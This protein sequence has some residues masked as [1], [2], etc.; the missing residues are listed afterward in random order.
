MRS[1][2]SR[3]GSILCVLFFLIILTCATTVVIPAQAQ[4]GVGTPTPSA[5]KTPIAAPGRVDVAPVARD[6]EIR[7]RLEKILEATGWFQ[8][9]KVEV[10]DGVVF[11]SGQTDTEEYKKWAGDLARN[12]QDVTAVVNQIELTQ[13]SIWDIQPA[14]AG[15]REM[16]T[17]VLR[18]I[19]LIGFGILVLLV[20]WIV[21]RLSANATR[22]ALRKRLPNPLLN[23]VAG[24]ASGV[25]VFLIGLYI[26]F[27][28]AGLA[29]VALTV[30]GG[31]GILGLILG[32]A[33]RDIS[34]NFLSSIF[35]SLQ[36]PF[37]IGDTVN[38]GNSTGIVQAL[39]T[40]ATVLHTFDGN[41]LQI[42]NATV[43][44]SNILN[45]TITPN[46]RM[47]FSISIGYND[48]ITAAQTTAMGVLE[49][50][51]AVLKDP[52]PWVLV[53]S[54]DNAVVNL[55]IYFW[56]DSTQYNGLKVKS[57][58]IRLVKR[59][60]HE[61]QIGMP[62]LARERIFPAS[63]S[64]RLV[65]AEEKQEPETKQPLEQGSGLIATNAEGNLS[66]DSS[67]VQESRD[68]DEGNLL[69]P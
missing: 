58:V 45:L 25:V 46:L 33:F 44:K 47:D 56:I 39:T 62:D 67:P 14:L 21:A 41:Q 57:A 55:H 27:E 34:E 42:P 4:S 54:L 20:T 63:L 11:L 49:E 37:R 30:L 68:E 35:L 52:E 19:P 16:W 48:S 28:I 26:V 64:V 15:L 61:A 51:P 69:K 50:H 53:E 7:D 8:T 1:R 38:I 22:S 40:R 43:Y 5:G 31:T 65:N 29:N 9:P 3:T 6:G 36:N 60:F 66:I 59:A 12:T 23:K 13:P 18:T 17:N 10:Q 24:T 2:R 32:I